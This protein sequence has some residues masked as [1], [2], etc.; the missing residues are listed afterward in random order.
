MNHTLKDLLETIVIAITVCVLL[1]TVV[2]G[3]NESKRIEKGISEEDARLEKA[4]RAIVPII[5]AQ[6]D[7]ENENK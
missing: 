7:I 4:Y 5:H 6:E 3:C 2:T 1:S